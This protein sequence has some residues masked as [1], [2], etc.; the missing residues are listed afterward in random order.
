MG[1]WIFIPTF[2]WIFLI[3]FIASFS[4]DLSKTCN[5]ATF[6]NMTVLIFISSTASH[7]LAQNLHE[8]ND[9][10]SQEQIVFAIAISALISTAIRMTSFSKYGA[11]TKK[12]FNILFLDLDRLCINANNSKNYLISKEIVLAR[13]EEY[14]K[15]FSTQSSKI[16]DVSLIKYQ[17]KAI[18]YL[19]K[20]EEF[21][22]ILFSLQ[23]LAANNFSDFL[24]LQDEIRHNLA[25]IKGIFK[26][27]KAKIKREALDKLESSEIKELAE[28]LY[29]KFA[30]FIEGG[31]MEL[32]PLAKNYSL[33]DIKDSFNKT[34]E[35]FRFSIKLA[36]AVALAMSAAIYFQVDHGIWIA[37]GMFSIIKIKSYE[38]SKASVQ[39]AVGLFLGFL[40][41]FLLIYFFINSFFFILILITSYFLCIYFKH[42]PYLISTTC[43][44]AN[45]ALF[46]A[47][48]GANFEQLLLFRFLDFLV[49]FAISIPIVHLLWTDKKEV[50][51]KKLSTECL[52]ALREISMNMKENFWEIESK[53]AQA[54]HIHASI[55]HKKIS[56]E[57]KHQRLN[58]YFLEAN[59]QLS[60]LHSLII[61]KDYSNKSSLEADLNMISLRFEMLKNCMQDLP[62]YFNLDIRERLI[63]EEGMLKNTLN[64]IGSIQNQMY[65]L[66]RTL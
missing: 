32:K 57:N 21:A 64:K 38:T 6:L 61:N 51:L 56:I 28:V 30:R 44:M 39:T 4:N 3:S 45:L 12:I 53:L 50:E 18:F 55:E 48:I 41:G 47:S 62:F 16:K 19:Y 58:R 24:F 15:L 10:K 34:N 17:G 65:E 23:E 35:I 60:F 46:F 36:L 49:S 1:I 52:L 27:K 20:C 31:S 33:S 8:I 59:A 9:I 25:Q 42:F 43:S 40:L 63:S 22:L 11:Y 2:I 66:I 37:V 29:E 5:T 13:I 54:I 26:D 7:D 14:K